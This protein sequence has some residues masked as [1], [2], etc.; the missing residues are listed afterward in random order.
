MPTKLL[1]Q[2]WLSFAQNSGLV[3][4]TSS[5]PVSTDTNP[6]PNDDRTSVLNQNVTHGQHPLSHVPTTLPSIHMHH[7]EFVRDLRE[8]I[9]NWDAK[10]PPNSYFDH[11]SSYFRV[12]KDLKGAVHII[13]HGQGHL[14]GHSQVVGI[15]EFCDW[16]RRRNTTTSVT[17]AVSANSQTGPSSS[18]TP[19][20]V[21]KAIPSTALKA[22]VQAQAT[23]SS[24]LLQSA[25]PHRPGYLEPG[26]SSSKQTSSTI[27]S[28]THNKEI[29]RQIAT[30]SAP[31]QT[32]SSASQIQ[33]PTSIFVPQAPTSNSLGRPLP[34]STVQTPS[35][36]SIPKTPIRQPITVVNG[37]PRSAKQ[38]D[39][40]SL[41]SHILFGLG[42]RRRETE[43]SPTVSIEPQP[44]RHS[45]Q[46]AS[47]QVVAGVSPS[48]S[49][50][51]G[52]ATPVVQKPNLPNGALT[53]PPSIQQPV[54]QD[55]ILPT[56]RRETQQISETSTASSGDQR[57][58][59][60]Q[61]QLVNVT[62]DVPSTSKV[63]AAVETPEVSKTPSLQNASTV[64]LATSSTIVQVSTLPPPVYLAGPAPIPSLLES[65]KITQPAS[66]TILEQPQPN[67]PA[68]LQ[69]SFTGVPGLGPSA[70]MPQKNQPLFLPSP[71]SSP[72]VDA[73]YDISITG[74]Q[75]ANV[76][77]RSKFSRST[78]RKNH[79]YV[80]APRR[81]SY[82]VK[83]FQLEKRKIVRM[84]S[85]GSVAGEEGV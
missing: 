61:Q 27:S 12:Y 35:S 73:N 49:Y 16:I 51:V 81:P 38:A 29:T 78:K 31:P 26:A 23:S 1:I 72:G 42:K 54:P 84:T 58:Q 53:A 79:A 15:D 24:Q 68:K 65:E 7:T 82:L 75:S 30:L 77:S 71:V 17:P 22:N 70:Q 25:I 85:R 67:T 55:F 10:A 39:K 2:I 60:G 37:L 43:T 64:P 69:F 36:A 45:T 47:G 83:Y 48:G 62:L 28:S 41:A 4:V 44:K 34:S 6:Y 5:N 14:K 59:G 9:K 57:Q 52:Q 50:T 8:A 80:L 76:A 66:S 21:Q 33:L 46:Q 20:N 74:T 11:S 63:A 32:G 13:M 3:A 18:S 19:S 40:K 56:I